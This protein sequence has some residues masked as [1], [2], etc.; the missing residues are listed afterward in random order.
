MKVG[1]KYALASRLRL[2]EARTRHLAYSRSVVGGVQTDTLGTRHPGPADVNR[3]VAGATRRGPD[4]AALPTEVDGGPPL[5]RTIMSPTAGDKLEVVINDRSIDVS[6]QVAALHRHLH[7]FQKAVDDFRKALPQLGLR[8]SASVEVFTGTLEA[9]FERRERSRPIDGRLLPVYLTGSLKGQI[10]LV[11][12]ALV[13]FFGVEL[14]RWG[15]EAVCGLELTVEGSIAGELDV[16]VPDGEAKGK[17]NG[18]LAVQLR[19]SARINLRS[20]WSAEATVTASTAFVAEAT[21]YDPTEGFVFRGEAKIEKTVVD[22]VCE[23]GGARHRIPR[24]EL[25]PEYPLGRF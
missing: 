11:K 21:V 10:T 14:R 9:S 25:F 18:R 4:G 17:I 15:V 8:F 13:A 5:E 3:A 23:R 20:L 2:E 7:S 1:L 12:V 16:T 19:G 22:V 6:A 24:I